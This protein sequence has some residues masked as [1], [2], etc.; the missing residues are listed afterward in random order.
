V[1]P[2][3]RS[4][5]TVLDK[6]VEPKFMLPPVVEDVDE[7]EDGTVPPEEEPPL[8]AEELLEPEGGLES[9]PPVPPLGEGEEPPLSGGELAP[10]EFGLCTGEEEGGGEGGSGEGEA[11]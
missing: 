11:G 4:E 7:G 8:P 10:I 2:V 1:L 3:P 6:E 9:D 5:V